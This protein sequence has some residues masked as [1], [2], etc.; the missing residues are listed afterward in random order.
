MYQIVSSLCWYCG[1]AYQFDI[2]ISRNQQ[3]LW[4]KI[5]VDDAHCV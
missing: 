5:P 4:F 3:V 1:F 2:A